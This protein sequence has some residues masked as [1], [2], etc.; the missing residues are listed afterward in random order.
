MRR[1]ANC[2]AKELNLSVEQKVSFCDTVW[3]IWLHYLSITGELGS[4]AWVNAALLLA[5]SLSEVLESKMIPEEEKPTN[6]ILRKHKTSDHCYRITQ[7]EHEWELIKTRLSQFQWVG[8]GLLY[9]PGEGREIANI[10][11]LSRKK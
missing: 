6:K 2:L 5:N 3:N 7:R 11:N 4:D 1:Q 8:W 10:L 9:E